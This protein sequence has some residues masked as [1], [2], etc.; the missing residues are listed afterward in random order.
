[1]A[2]EQQPYQNKQAPPSDEIDLRQLFNAIG[3]FFKRIWYS[4]IGFIILIKH[5]TYDHRV[6]LVILIVAGV[7][8]GGGFTQIRTDYYRSSMLLSS[9][10]F[11]GQLIESTIEKL[12][13]LAS[14][15][16]KESLTELLDISPETARL[17][18]GFEAVPFVSEEE[19][20]EVE[21]LREQLKRLNVDNAQIEQITN[22]IQ[23]ENK[24]TYEIIAYVYDPD[25]VPDLQEPLV[26]YFK[27]NPFISK[28]L[29]IKEENRKKEITKLES[30]IDKLDSLKKGMFRYLATIGERTREGSNNVILA[31]DNIANPLSVFQ[32]DLVLYRQKQ[33]I[34]EQLALEPEFEV[35]D[36][37]TTFSQPE[38]PGLV[39]T[40]GLGGL[41][42]LGIGY[43]F[44]LLRGI[45]SYLNRFEREK[46]GSS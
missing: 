23:I 11:K 21:V 38:N 30:E 26:E 36:G 42:F 39:K 19:I 44:I 25:I 46:M 7:V 33:R 31:E 22:R 13:R 40:A 12:N 45:N 2:E 4:F 24:S 37:F 29:A 17:I 27:S 9:T 34:E 41:I 32:E 15:E 5:S 18:K 43:L 3:N 14:V 1:M 20:I 10:Y 16:D 6:A 8:L 28:R 35:I